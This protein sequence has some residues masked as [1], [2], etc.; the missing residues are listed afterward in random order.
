MKLHKHRITV[1]TSELLNSETVRKYM[2]IIDM[3]FMKGHRYVS[4]AGVMLP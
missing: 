4:F 1:L 3:K 2:G